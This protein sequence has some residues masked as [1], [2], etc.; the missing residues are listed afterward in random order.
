MYEPYEEKKESRF[1]KIFDR[2]KDRISTARNFRF[3]T[4]TERFADKIWIRTWAFVALAVLVIGGLS[5]T[6]YAVYTSRITETQSQLLILERQINA[7]EDELNGYK[8]SLA[9]CETNVNNT[10]ESL[11]KTEKDL[12]DTKAQL[13]ACN[14]EYNILLN[15]SATTQ[16]AYIELK[17][18]Y[19]KLQAEYKNV[20]CSYAI[21]KDCNY[22]TVVESVVQCCGKIEDKFYCGPQF[23]LTDSANVKQVSEYC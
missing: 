5:Y 21:S 16:T 18:T 3:P 23:V 20:E 1:K 7:L 17:N 14:T 12:T 2:I 10:K 19:E 4:F 22:Y 13:V 15:T 11:A 6:G 9:V 8:T